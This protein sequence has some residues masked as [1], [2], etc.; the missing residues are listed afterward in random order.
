[1]ARRLAS[2]PSIGPDGSRIGNLTP[3]SAA[4]SATADNDRERALSARVDACVAD[5][6]SFAT[7]AADTVGVI[8]AIWD[9][10]TL[11]TV[12]AEL[13]V[14]ALSSSS[15]WS[16]RGGG[17]D[18]GGGPGGPLSYVPSSAS[19]STYQYAAWT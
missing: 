3:R 1:V 6:V 16:G 13:E 14:V 7:A 18:V 15:S 9:D 5:I 19:A 11:Q 2:G 10:F 4:I 17:G 12:A 8:N